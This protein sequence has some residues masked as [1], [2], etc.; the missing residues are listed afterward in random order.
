M[1]Q[2][3]IGVMFSISM[4]NAAAQQGAHHYPAKLVVAAD[5]SGDFVRIQDAVNATRDLGYARVTIYIRKGV[6]AEKLVIPAWKTNLTLMGESADSTIITGDDYSGKNGINTFT[7]YTLLVAGN[8]THLINL[9]IRNT[10]GAVGQA[11][12]LHLAAD[13]VIVSGCAIRGYQDT[14]YAAG[15][16][17]RQYVVD[18]FIEGTTDFIFGEAQTVFDRCHIRSLSNSYI[19]AAATRPGQAFGFVLM[20]CALDARDGVDRVYLGRP[21]RPYARTVIL[22]SQLG[23]HIVPAGWDAWSGDV[24]FPDK[25]RTAYMAEYRNTGPGASTTARVRWSHQLTQAEARTYTVS[26]ILKGEDGWNPEV[27]LRAYPRQH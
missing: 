11:V 21:W 15:E 2:F 14:C 13:R 6:Y 5:G 4:L 26:N 23:A 25:E 18:C 9:T 3:V 1:R 17:N 10:A 12:A 20:N 16:R 22:T 24:M 27:V 8:D 19:T 7:S